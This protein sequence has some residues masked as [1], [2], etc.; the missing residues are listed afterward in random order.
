MRRIEF[1][2]LV[3]LTACWVVA[4]AALLR[5]LPLAGRLSLGLYPLYGLASA[6][7]WLA[8][9]TFLVRRA[10]AR[11]EPTAVHPLLRRRL[12]LLYLLQPPAVLYLLRGLAPIAE[13]QVA[14]LVPLYAHLVFLLFFMVPVSF[15]RSR[16]RPLSRER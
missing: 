3:G 14:P 9:N 15:Q 2:L 7:G 6:L 4:A 12:W 11:Q 5:W 1:F 16:R 13:Q 8:G 10:R